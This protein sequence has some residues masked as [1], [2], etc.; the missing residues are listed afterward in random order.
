MTIG[1]VPG[2]SVYEARVDKLHAVRRWA[3]TDATQQ[4]ILDAATDV[5][6]A[7]GFAA[8]TMADIVSRS[9]ASVGSIYHHF[10]GKKELF[11]AI[12]ERLAV[13]IDQSVD[14]ATEQAGRDG[15]GGHHTLE[16]SAR[17]YLDAMWTHRRAAMVLAA[18][19]SPAGFETIRRGTMLRGFHRWMSV[20]EPDASPRGR[21]LTRVLI[22]VLAE[23][24]A[25]VIAC[26]DPA[27]VRPITDATVESIARLTC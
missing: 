7:R 3:R 12:F 20:V 11:L 19:D 27:D 2:Q 18:D 26:E 4:R 15:T 14:A 23:A 5:F 9:G 13:A 25:M 6:A 16:I 1:T 17:A 22:A 10:G 21:L 8:S 24:S